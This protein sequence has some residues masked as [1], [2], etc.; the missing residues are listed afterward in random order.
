MPLPSGAT[1]LRLE[2]RG[3]MIYASTSADGIQWL[4][5]EPMEMELPS[6]VSLGVAAGHNTSSPFE[7]EFDDFKVFVEQ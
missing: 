5:M 2:R 4:S 7:V 1:Y 6:V 3:G